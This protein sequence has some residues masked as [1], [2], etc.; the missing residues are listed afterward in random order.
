MGIARREKGINKLSSKVYNDLGENYDRMS[1]ANIKAENMYNKA[2]DADPTYAKPYYNLGNFAF[3][4][5]G[6]RDE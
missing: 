1:R 6:K 3:I 4:N 2:I 5:K